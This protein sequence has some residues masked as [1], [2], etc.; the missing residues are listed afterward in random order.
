MHVIIGGC[1]R[2][3]A[4]LGDQLSR[5]EHD[6]VIID[7]DATSFDRIGGAFNGE[8]IVG[9]IIDQQTLERAG[10]MRADVLVAVTNLDNANLMAVQIARELFEV[11]H[12]IA[13]LF[14]PQREDSYR[15]M[16]VAYVSGTRLVARAIMKQLSIDTFP[17]HVGFTE[18]EV[19]IVELVVTQKGNGVTVG[20]LQNRGDLRV[21]AVERD[22]RVRIPAGNDR[23]R[24]DDLLVAAI[25]GGR[26]GRKARELVGRPSTTRRI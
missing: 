20:E 3:G 5:D 6:V 4:Q 18:G 8:T 13:R 17:P 9:S 7:A 25:R 21:A 23:L 15:K 19:D 2:V 12:T 22:G 24:H 26:P 11:S 10:I 1:G 14:N 16:G